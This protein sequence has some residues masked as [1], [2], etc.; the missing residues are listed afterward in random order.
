MKTYC[1]VSN[2]PTEAQFAAAIEDA[3]TVRTSLDGT[4]AVLKWVGPTP[5]AFEGETV[6]AHVNI[7]PIMHSPEWSEPMIDNGEP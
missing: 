4:L 5:A 6:Y 7:L 1:I 2:P 3:S